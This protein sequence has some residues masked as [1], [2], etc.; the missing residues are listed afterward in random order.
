MEATS[1]KAA[2]AHHLDGR[3]SAVIGTHTHV[4]TA[5]A[6]LLPGGTA[7]ISDI[8]MCGPYNSIIGRE[9]QSVIRH[10]TTAMYAPFGIGAGDERMCGALVRIDADSGRALRI[11]RLEY[12]ADHGRPPFSG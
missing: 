9:K 4:P 5:D 3:V 8:G 11:D 2:L 12:P 10:M 7:F 6:R 1:E